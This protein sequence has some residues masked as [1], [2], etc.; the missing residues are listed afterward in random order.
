MTESGEISFE[1][2][3][4]MT[5]VYKMLVGKYYGKIALRRQM[6][7]CENIKMLAE[8]KEIDLQ[9]HSIYSGKTTAANSCQFGKKSSGSTNEGEFFGRLSYSRLQTK[10]SIAEAWFTG[11]CLLL[12]RYS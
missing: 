10:N 1:R 3:E 5:N 7:S 2:T 9:F 8:D 4:E 12:G 6:N 11:V